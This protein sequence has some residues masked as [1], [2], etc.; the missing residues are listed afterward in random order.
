MS[1]GTGQFSNE[2]VEMANRHMKKCSTSLATRETQIK[3][4]L[5]FALHPSQNGYHQENK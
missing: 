2:E 3:T 5:R 4:A 1:N